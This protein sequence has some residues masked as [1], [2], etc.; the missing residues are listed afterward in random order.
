ML[1][2]TGLR[3]H[4]LATGSLKDGLDGGVIRLYS[5]TV[6]ASADDSIG[7]AVLLCTVSLASAGT[8]IT[9]AASASA[10]VITKNSEK[11]GPASM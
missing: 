3:N 2:S 9:L 11:S 8:G 6:P 1:K 4:L 7:A 10:G 5:G